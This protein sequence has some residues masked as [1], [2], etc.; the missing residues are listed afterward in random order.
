[1][2]NFIKQ[3]NLVSSIIITKNKVIKMLRYC[4]YNILKMLK[5]KVK[6]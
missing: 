4:I 2:K 5:G 3:G 1:M 6:L